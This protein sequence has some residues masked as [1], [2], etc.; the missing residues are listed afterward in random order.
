M[1]DEEEELLNSFL[2]V[3][4][5]AN[6]CGSMMRQP[7]ELAVLL[8]GIV[9]GPLAERCGKANTCDGREEWGVAVSEANGDGVV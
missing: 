5:E 1:P 2:K 4:A 6:N 3:S 7:T 9:I 8:E